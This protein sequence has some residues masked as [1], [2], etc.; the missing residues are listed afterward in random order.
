MNKIALLLSAILTAFV[1]VA[2]GGLIY[3][4][5]TP[6]QTPA[7]PTLD[8]QTIQ[9]IQQREAAY[10]SLI[11]QANNQIMQLQAQSQ[12]VQ[13]APTPTSAPVVSL[14]PEQAA[15]IAA[16][17]LGENQI[18]SVETSPWNGGTAYLVTFSSGNVV[19]VSLD[20]QILSA[21]LAANQTTA[22]NPFPIPS[23]EHEDD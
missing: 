21:Q 1:L 5:R 17:V 3:A 8:A 2:V 9:V 14:P 12:P 4:I 19:I 20:G 22:N 18:F 6:A 7:A 15:Q 23:G 16:Q 11:A 10:Q 13:V